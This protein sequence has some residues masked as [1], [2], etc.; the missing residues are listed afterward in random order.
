[1]FATNPFAAL[2]A[3]IPPAVMQGYVLLMI[4]LVAAG[5]IFDIV[6]KGSAKYFFAN[7]RRTKGKTRELGGGELASIAL[8]TALVDVLASGEFCNLRR[9]IAHLLTMY[10]FILYVVSTAVMIFGYPS[11]ATA[12][13]DAWPHLWWIGALM[14]LVGGYWFWFFIRVDV[15]AEGNSPFRVVHADLFVL[16]LLASVTLGVIWAWL[17]AAASSVAAL[18][19][20]ALYI[21]ATTVL[22]G[23][24]PWSKFAHMF[25]KPAAAFEK[26]VSNANG[27]R[28]NLP[29]PADKP[30]QFGSAR[31]L[32]QHY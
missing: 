26:R 7:W 28:A 32:P 10:G 31:E 22:F 25:F 21:L 24:V 18:A 27:T 11:A 12:T 14:L 1:M 19:F 4:V 17:Q 16:S 5:T 2:S 13:P 3:W 30:E 15:A 8:K 20:F 9:R 23:S 6:H 29:A